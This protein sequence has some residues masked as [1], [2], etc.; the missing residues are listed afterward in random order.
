MQTGEQDP[1]TC[2]LE[3]FLIQDCHP[4]GQEEDAS[5]QKQNACRI[6]VIFSLQDVVVAIV[7]DEREDGHQSE[8]SHFHRA[9]EGKS[10]GLKKGFWGFHVC[11]GA[12]E[13]FGELWI[14][15]RF[16]F[17]MGRRNM[18]DDVMCRFPS[19]L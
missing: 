8:D 12:F 17:L 11:G 13:N 10:V 9:A 14:R 16:G 3:A 6:A 15:H 2:A 19:L 4:K 7:E 18:I 5:E 1:A